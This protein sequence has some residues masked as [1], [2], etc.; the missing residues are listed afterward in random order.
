MEKA[1]LDIGNHDVELVVFLDTREVIG[2]FV[3][4]VPAFPIGALLTGA[5]GGQDDPDYA[6]FKTCTVRLILQGDATGTYTPSTGALKGKAVFRP[7]TDDTTG[8]WAARPKSFSSD[9]VAE[10][11][12]VK[13]SGTLRGTK[14]SGRIAFDPSTKWSATAE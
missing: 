12:T 8:C 14:A 1:G 5:F 6:E 10:A 7:E 3:V 2:T 11:S 4:E 9:E 13:W